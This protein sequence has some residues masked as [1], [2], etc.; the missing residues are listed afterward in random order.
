M[1]TQKQKRHHVKGRRKQQQCIKT[2]CIQQGYTFQSHDDNKKLR[3][4][5][6]TT[7]ISALHNMESHIWQKV[8]DDVYS[9]SS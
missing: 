5:D 1:K 7:M 2:T 6:K 9:N 3:S 8:H 4:N